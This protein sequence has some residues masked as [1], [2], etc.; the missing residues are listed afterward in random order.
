ME[1]FQ[2]RCTYLLPFCGA[3]VGL[4]RY[5]GFGFTLSYVT[6]INVESTS[7]LIF[8]FK[9]LTQEG[10]TANINALKTQLLLSQMN[11]AA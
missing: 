9:T 6:G 8:F 4:S 10:T 2:E 5:S 3:F 7:E 1:S 11:R